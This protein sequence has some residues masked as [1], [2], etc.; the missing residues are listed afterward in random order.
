MTTIGKKWKLSP[1]KKEKHDLIIK[2]KKTR[3]KISNTLKRKGIKPPSR[4]GS[5]MTISNIEKIRERMKGNNHSLGYKHTKQARE[6]MGN[7]HRGL[8]MTEIAKK[9]ISETRKRLGLGSQSGELSPNWRGGRTALI[10]LLRTCLKYREWRDF[11]FKRDDY[12]CVWCGDNKGG[13]LEA[14]HIKAF[15][16][17]IKEFKIQNFNE[18]MECLALWDINNGRTL[19]H[20]CHLKTETYGGNKK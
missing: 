15:S 14:D 9:K 19:C 11:V 20:D 10:I 8:K 13:N 17:I 4:K 16:V 6:N 1:E 7:A 5:K 3:E 18:A 2:D 12:T